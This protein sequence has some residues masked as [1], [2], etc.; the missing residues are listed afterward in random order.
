[1][2]PRKSFFL[3]LVCTLTSILA[4]TNAQESSSAYYEEVGYTGYPVASSELTA[5]GAS[6]SL[7]LF[8]RYCAPDGLLLYA[9]DQSGSLYL[10]L[11]IS[12]N[13]LLLEFD[14]GERKQQV[15]FQSIELESGVW[16]NATLRGLGGSGADAG[17]LQLEV[18]QELATV[19]NVTGVNFE[20]LD[21]PLY[22][23]GHPSISTIMVCGGKCIMLHSTAPPPQ[24]TYLPTH[25]PTYV[26]HTHINMCNCFG[27]HT[28]K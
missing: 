2:K 4:A 6:E 10:A 20:N 15:L 11:G 5:A 18:N 24:P 7:S 26:P 9:T 8:F 25:P 14:T 23:G 12:S 16:Y 22:I 19:G 17:D 1:M 28:R 3:I 13:H 27:C 21:G